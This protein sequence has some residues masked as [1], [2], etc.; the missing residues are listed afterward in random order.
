[1]KKK[2]KIALDVDDV[3]GV[4]MA[5]AVTLWNGETG[6]S[7]TPYDVTGWCSEAGW[8]K[9]FSDETFVATQAVSDGAKWFVQELIKRGCDV[10]VT[11][12]VPM[13]VAEARTQW[14]MKNF[15]EI[16]PGNIIIGKRKD[17]Y[18]VDIMID[19]AAHN[20]LNSRA[21]YPILMRKPWNQHVTGLMAVNN[22]E[23]CLNLIDTIM[24]QNGYIESSEP[25]DVVCLVGPSGSGKHDII[26]ALRGEGYIV[27]RIFTT[28]PAVKQDFYRIVDKSA[29]EQEK[30]AHHYAETTS[31][32]GYYYGIRMEDM[33]DLMAARRRKQVKLVIPIDICGANAL[34]RIYGECVKTVYVRRN[35]GELVMNILQKDIPD[36]EKTLRILALDGEERNEELCDY[37]VTHTTTASVVQQIKAI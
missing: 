15:P 4:C 28:N 6:A 7:M 34:K 16:N 11:T 21:K 5:S 1:M 3:L 37:S 26:N 36:K 14:I 13:G 9:Y 35:R 31:Y 12:A 10:L 30:A 33:V 17:I 19:D 27:P 24:R 18:D 23:E 25:T 20:I 29:F 2:L 8:L 32:A 22:F